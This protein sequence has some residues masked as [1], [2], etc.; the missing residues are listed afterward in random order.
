ME[1]VGKGYSIK[2]DY[3]IANTIAKELESSGSCDMTILLIHGQA[4]SAANALGKDTV[5][6]LVLGGHAHLN[7]AGKTEWDLPYIEP[8]CYGQAYSYAEL[9]FTKTDSGKISFNKVRNHGFC[10]IDKG[11]MTNIEENSSELDKNILALSD[12]AL[13]T[14][15]E[16]LNEVIGYI[17]TD[18]IYAIDYNDEKYY[19][20]GSGKR[21]TIMS[22]W[23]CDITR[24]IGNAQVAFVNRGGVR[25]GF[26]VE[27]GRK[28]NTVANVYEMF[29]FGNKIYV[30]NISY[31]EFLELL[32]YAVKA[33]GG[34]DLLFFMTG[35]DCYFSNE[36]IGALIDSESGAVIY[37][38][39]VFS[40]GW[41]D[42]NIKIAVCDY[43]GTAS[44]PTK[45]GADNPLIAWNST[46]RLIESA[47]ID[48]EGAIAVLKAESLKNNGLL[49]IDTKA[50][51]IQGSYKR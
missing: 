37:S 13:E 34:D 28:N 17:T 5:I 36:S 29:P 47:V 23:M 42:R 31:K 7:V 22:N 44:R 12:K 16:Q 25:T 18:A 14:V 43:I 30:Y 39:G 49:S 48:N 33:G 6:D 38:D 2:E 21:A 11:K 40:E 27:N 32:N 19:I 24:K 45:S 8:K 1:F 20:A 4:D 15:S 46:D 41:S 3:N 10:D 51:F 26:Y 9:V 50:H 35:I